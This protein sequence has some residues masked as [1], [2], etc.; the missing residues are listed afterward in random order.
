MGASLGVIVAMMDAIAG[1]KPHMRIG[2]AVNEGLNAES[3]ADYQNSSNRDGDHPATALSRPASSG[4]I[5]FVRHFSIV[6]HST[7]LV[8]SL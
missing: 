4:V 8:A 5:M 7:K 6:D 2:P 1:K 3:A